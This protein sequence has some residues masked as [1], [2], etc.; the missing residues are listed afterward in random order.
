LEEKDAGHNR[1]AFHWGCPTARVARAS[2][3]RVFALFLTVC[4]QR[5][6]AFSKKFF[7]HRL[8]REA[9]ER[10]RDLYF[11]EDR[12]RWKYPATRWFASPERGGR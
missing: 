8:R 11:D 4:R 5:W 3:Y 9:Q 1:A 2:D 10:E 12:Q 6:P 7:F